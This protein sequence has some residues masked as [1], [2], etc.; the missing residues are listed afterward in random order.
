M[1]FILLQ[2]KKKKLIRKITKLEQEQK[3]QILKNEKKCSHNIIE[4]S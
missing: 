2:N 3:K 4:I 1:K